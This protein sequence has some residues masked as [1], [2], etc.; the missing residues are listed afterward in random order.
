MYA[1]RMKIRISAKTR[2]LKNNSL[3]I[4]LIGYG[5]LDIRLLITISL[6]LSA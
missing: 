4:S 1:N 6:K 3:N 5:N 2:T